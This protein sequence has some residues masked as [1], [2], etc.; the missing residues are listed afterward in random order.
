MAVDW[1]VPSQAVLR[2]VRANSDDDGCEEVITVTQASISWLFLSDVR[3]WNGGP[4]GGWTGG[5]RGIPLQIRMRD[6]LRASCVQQV[7]R[8]RISPRIVPPSVGEAPAGCLRRSAQS[9]RSAASR[10]RGGGYRHED[11]FRWRGAPNRVGPGG[12]LG[13]PPNR[14]ASTRRTQAEILIEGAAQPRVRKPRCEDHHLPH[15]RE[16]RSKPPRRRSRRGRRIG[17][18]TRLPGENLRVMLDAR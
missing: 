9:A 16:L 14:R 8:R 13:A 17:G 4:S 12:C 1:S 15:R 5:L 11:W 3:V 2:T 7:S 6:A 10:W 18:P